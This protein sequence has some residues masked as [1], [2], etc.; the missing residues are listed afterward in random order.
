MIRFLVSRFVQ[1]VVVILAV[2]TITF[3]LSQMV[4]GGA[5]RNER[6]VSEE[7]KKAQEEYFGLNK[8]WIVRLGLTLKHYVTLDLPDSY[9]Y[10]G[11][12]VDE[13][14][15]SGFPVSATV[16]IAA[17]VIALGI[18]VP[19]G[20]IAALRPNTLEDRGSTLVA[21]LGICTPSMVL[22][23]LIAMLFGLKLRWFNVAGWFD[24]TDWVLPAL[25]LGVIY[26]A[27]IARLARGSLRETL[28]QEFIRTA[29]AKGAGETSVVFLHA[30]KLASLPVLNFLGPA[31]AGL[32][33]G[34][35]IVETIFQLPGLGQFFIAAATNGDH[36]LTI[37]ISTFYAALIVSF[38]LLVD[39]LQALLN[40]RIRLHA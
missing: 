11:R 13:I 25:T 9:H 28:A 21:T 4:P 19:L 27:Y 38:N 8:P 34:S 35:F 32:L 15:A 29:R 39:I 5:I 12:G 33:T 1:G 40:P 37:A 16:G 10:K 18:G 17:L 20:A 24:S 26:S 22:G 14:I 3:T 36:Q 2:I 7:T 30:M 23:P 31:A 6:N